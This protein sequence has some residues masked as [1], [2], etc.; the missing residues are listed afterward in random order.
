VKNSLYYGDNLEAL[1]LSVADETV[2][3]C[4]IDPPF[5]SSRSY[6]Q[7][8]QRSGNGEERAQALAFTD[9][10]AWDDAASE[11]LRAILENSDGRFTSP[12]RELIKGLQQVIG[13]GGLLA[14]L[15]SMA[16]RLLEIHR[17]LKPAGSF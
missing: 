12:T 8:Y 9:C 16:Q 3:L 15:V 7:V 5:Y 10:W 4:Y 13:E 17:T 11:G 2:D 1:R 6:H 14:Y